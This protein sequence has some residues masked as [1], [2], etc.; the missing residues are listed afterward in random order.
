MVHQYAYILY[1]ALVRFRDTDKCWPV[2]FSFSNSVHV[3]LDTMG[4]YVYVC[5][6]FAHWYTHKFSL[7]PYNS[8]VLASAIL[9]SASAPSPWLGVLFLYALV[10]SRALSVF[11][12]SPSDY[13]ML[14]VGWRCQYGWG[15]LR[16]FRARENSLPHS[17]QPVIA[18][19]I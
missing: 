5:M 11:F 19:T 16:G 15:C 3:R 12:L 4:R 17:F 10:Y 8:W 14:G 13:T 2:D 1:T 6:S 7:S 9:D 18:R